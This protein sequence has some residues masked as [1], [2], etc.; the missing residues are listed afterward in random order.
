MPKVSVIVPA[1][2]AMA[3]LPTTIDNVLQQSYDDYEVII[4]ND[5]STDEI[6]RWFETITDPRLRLVSQVN[7]GLAGA[8]NT[9]IHHARGDY[10]AFLDADDLWEST[11]LVKQV[12]CLDDNPEVGLVYTWSTLIDDK[13]NLTGRSFEFKV[14]GNVWKTLIGWNIVSCGSVAMV[15]RQCFETC[16][17]FDRNLGSYLED[18]DM[19]LRLATKY[20]F[21]VVPEIL[22]YYRQHANSASRNWDA[23]L[24]SAQLAIEKTFNSAPSQLQYL[25]NQSYGWMHLGLAWKPLQIVN[26]DF[27]KADYFRK[28]AL[29]YYPQIMFT[30]QYW[31]LSI[32]ITAMRWLGNNGYQRFLSFVYVLRRLR[33]S[34]GAE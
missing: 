3:Y 25:K 26:K 30:P 31:R 10:L 32:A 28:M 18:W 20:N 12:Q 34:G 7:Q 23:M 9:G 27:Q 6:D 33:T 4:V 24:S 13:G 14:E 11:K 22:V 17:V 19:W 15:R 5:G 21:K 29:K 8:R 2:N 16:G 1:Y